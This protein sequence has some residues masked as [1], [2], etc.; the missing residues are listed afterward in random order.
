MTPRQFL[1]D[2]V[3]P[4]VK[5]FH[6]NY[7]NLRYAYNAIA[8]VDSLA[9]HLY[10]WANNHALAPFQVHRTIPIIGHYSPAAIRT[11]RCCATWPKL[12]STSISAE[13]TRRLRT[14]I[15]F[16]R[17]QLGMARADTARGATA[18]FNRC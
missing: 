13:A 1:N 7:D 15:R 5:D 11:L 2:I 14:R 8:A 3:C 4:N 6:D 10:V 17:E 9:A 12:R 16:R 18:E